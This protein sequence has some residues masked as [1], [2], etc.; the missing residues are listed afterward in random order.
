MGKIRLLWDEGLEEVKNKTGFSHCQITCLDSWFTSLDKGETGTLSREDFQ[1]IPELAMNPLRDQIIDAFFT[2]G[3]E[4]L[5]FHG[6]MRPLAHI[7]PTE[8]NEKSQ[9]VNGPEPLNMK[10]NFS[11]QSTQLK[12]ELKLY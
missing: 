4:Q 11:F 7:Q 8:D 2:E 12:L 5:N 9:R 6:F 3:K 1:W 10:F